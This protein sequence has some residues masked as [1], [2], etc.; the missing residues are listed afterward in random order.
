MPALCL[1]NEQQYKIKKTKP[2]WYK[3]Q[4]LMLFSPKKQFPSRSNLT[5]VQQESKVRKGFC[6]FLTS[7]SYS[8]NALL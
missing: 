1:W 2:Q 6:A 3:H 8:E 4:E 5:T 7:E